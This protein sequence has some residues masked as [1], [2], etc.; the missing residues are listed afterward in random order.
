MQSRS[1][2]SNLPGSAG[3]SALS[4]IDDREAAIYFGHLAA[5][6]EIAM[7][8]APRE[9]QIALTWLAAEI[10]RLRTRLWSARFEDIE[11]DG[12]PLGS[13]QITARCDPTP[14]EPI[15]IARQN[16][17]RDEGREIIALAHPFLEASQERDKAEKSLLDF[18][19]M[20]LIMEL[21][22]NRAKVRIRDHKGHRVTIAVS[23]RRGVK[24]RAKD[25]F[26]Y[27]SAS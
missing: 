20:R 23:D 1:P 22:E 15:E 2:A 14:E 4:P 13:W 18:S 26:R 11:V 24:A 8:S 5:Q 6:A 10:I 21:R 3:Y 25:F 17:L 16:W 19:A 27:L 7:P 9:A 12:A